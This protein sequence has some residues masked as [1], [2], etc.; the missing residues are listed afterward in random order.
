MCPQTEGI[1]LGLVLLDRDSLPFNKLAVDL[2]FEGAWS[3]WSY[4]SQFPQVSTDLRNGS[5]ACLVMTHADESRH[6][7]ALFWVREGGLLTIRARQ[8]DWNPNDPEDLDFA[9]SVIDGDVPSDGWTGL[10]Q[11]LLER[12]ERTT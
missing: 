6:V 10:A 5:D 3:S 7:S 4:K 2:A 12:L 9:V 8:H 1:A 11:G